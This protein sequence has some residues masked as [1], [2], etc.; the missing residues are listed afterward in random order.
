MTMDR[1]QALTHIIG[2]SG[3]AAGSVLMANPVLAATQTAEGWT[4]AVGDRLA[5][6]K[7]DP[8]A[9]AEAA[10]KAGNGCMYQVFHGIISSLAQSDS[11]DAAKFAQVPTAL[12]HY[13]Y[14]GILGEGSVCGNVNAS[15]ML[16]NLLSING[17]AA[18]AYLTR[19][20]RYYEQESLPLRDE[21]FLNA[22]GA[23]T[24]ELKAKVGKPTVAG[25]LLCHSSI[26]NWARENNKNAAEK[27]ER[28]AELS[29]SIAYQIV[30]ILNKAMDGEDLAG[31]G[32]M[33]ESVGSCKACHSKADSF[34]PSVMTNMECDTCHGGH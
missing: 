4:L 12:A 14:A 6:A 9:V 33:T 1:R 31:I 16:F 28:C 17:E 32:E 10:Y 25:S 2:I 30:V 29:A 15:G 18:N 8:Y 24:D 23:N 19:V 21:A 26:T 3:A 7:L 34:G 22:I 13:G 11:P 27:G 20:L 5:Y